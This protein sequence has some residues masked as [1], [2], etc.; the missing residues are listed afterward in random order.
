[1][2]RNDVIVSRADPRPFLDRGGREPFDRIT[3]VV[4][5][6]LG[7]PQVLLV[8]GPA[9]APVL[10]SHSGLEEPWSGLREL[11]PLLAALSSDAIGAGVPIA[12]EDARRHPA[13]ASG[14]GAGFRGFAAVPVR[15]RGG[16]VLGIL[17]ATAAAES[18]PWGR[19][20]LRLLLDM[21]HGAGEEIARR[22]RAMERPA[23]PSRRPA[24]PPEA[25]G[26][27]PSPAA[28][29][30]ADPQPQPAPIP[31]T[32]AAPAPDAAAVRRR[33]TLPARL[34][35]ELAEAEDG[36][37]TT[38]A[39][40]RVVEV[41]ERAAAL[42]GVDPAAA[43][44]R[45]LWD[46][47]PELRGTIVEQQYR[48]AAAGGLVSFEEYWPSAD[49]W[50][51]SHLH[52][53]S[54]ELSILLRDV[55]ARKRVEEELRNSEERFRSLFEDSRDAMYVSTA[56]GRIVEAN[57]AFLELIGYEAEELAALNAADLYA[58]PLERRH[59]C[60]QIDAAGAVRD[61]RVLLRRRDGSIR[62]CE[63][64]ATARYGGS[65]DVIGYHGVL[66]DVTE[67]EQEQEQLAHHAFHDA[68]TGLPN[69]SLFMDRLEQLVRHARRHEGYRFAVLFLDLDRFKIINDSFGHSAGDELL[70]LVARRLEAALRQEDTVA[71]LG[72]DEFALILD[73][74]QDVSDATR[75]AD[76]IQS[77]LA[78][79]FR[80][81]ERDVYTSTSIGIAV[82]T[83]GY[84]S[85]S[86]V[87]RDADTAMYRA[88][89]G[90]RSRYE[91]FDPEMQRRVL[92]QLQL[93]ADLRRAVSRAEFV[94]QYLPV[95]SLDGRE[96]IGMEAL[97]RWVHPDRGVLMPDEFIPVAEETGLIMDI[98]WWVLGEA[99]RQ[100]RDW[101]PLLPQPARVSI[102]V[103]LSARQFSQ[104]DL[105]ETI[106]RILAE[107][108]LEP[109]FLRLE[110][111]EDMIMEDPEG[112]L[113]RLNELRR[114]GI[115]V[116]LDNFGT[117]YS[118]I[119]HL[120]RLPI[121]LLKI[122][123]S[124]VRDLDGGAHGRALVQSILALGESLSIDS[125]AEGVETPEQLG[126]LRELG[127]KF[128][129]GY[130]FSIP[131][132]ADAATRMLTEGPLE[133]PAG[134]AE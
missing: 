49:R 119:S 70:T 5:R 53:S 35:A 82:S 32:A 19:E 126:R 125:V 106:D 134:D 34:F 38:D 3:R 85:A 99:C 123:R 25:G 59:F 17:C 7:A 117:G 81:L 115:Q 29:D 95:V 86:E 121:S 108:G 22:L 132:D 97:V 43:R 89:A 36:L 55:S 63:I 51:E 47:R 127:T 54:G 33:G 84:G 109:S 24:D 60:D 56:D 101:Q 14:P 30:R 96:V 15:G 128:G 65:G 58:D 111:T 10:V 88:K 50:I 98:G 91:I 18:G 76:R 8:A 62:L 112:A 45:E 67:R 110:V 116:S 78:V 120:Q 9:D 42:L 40:W 77:D 124:F 64:S 129:Q 16:A 21:A 1:V 20:D 11:P 31:E 71:R 74:I 23:A 69:R 75:V 130:L 102:S 107:A 44:G 4:R 80:I 93:E 48:G 133:R 122:D 100:M 2:N 41:D 105:V 79:P 103:N 37:L 52:A 12:I 72:G 28:P 118:S 27:G 39:A 73:G 26:P 92:A 90:G 114:R 13:V 68:L 46:L 57:G 83:S 61:H 87:L 66:H 131:L 104:P 94:V 6:A 113:V